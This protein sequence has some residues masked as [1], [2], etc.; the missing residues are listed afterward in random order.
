MRSAARR[1]ASH[2]A[3]PRAVPVRGV[4]LS[5]NGAPRAIPADATAV[6]L[7]VTIAEAGEAGYATVWPC[8]T[9]RPEASNVNFPKGGTVANGVVAPIGPDGSVCVFSDK[10]AHLIVDVAGWFTGGS[11]PGFTGNVP[12]RLL[13]TRN[14]I[15]PAPI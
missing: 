4:T 9:T 15:G 6:A 1:V 2:P 8:G 11:T 13:D 7:N 14:S 5:V 12:R 3:T 10:D